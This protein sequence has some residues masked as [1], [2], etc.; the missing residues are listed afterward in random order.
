MAIFVSASLTRHDGATSVFSPWRCSEQFCAIW[1]PPILRHTFAAER[2]GGQE[3]SHFFSWTIVGCDEVCRIT[4]AIADALSIPLRNLA[5]SDCLGNAYLEEDSTE[6]KVQLAI[7]DV[8]ER[9]ELRP[10]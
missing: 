5:S 7:V 3:I 6:K 4:A 2:P 1:L 10:T 9:L 8:K